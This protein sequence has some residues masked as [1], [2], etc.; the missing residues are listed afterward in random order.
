MEELQFNC[1]SFLAKRFWL[2]CNTRNETPGEVIREFMLREILKE[3]P[4]FEQDLKDAMASRPAVIK[5]G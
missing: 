5:G 2:L 1:P 4:Y 3:D